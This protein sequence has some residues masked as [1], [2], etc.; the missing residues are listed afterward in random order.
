M[1]A[2]VFADPSVLGDAQARL[3]NP[4]I[5][6]EVAPELLRFAKAGHVSDSSNDAGSDHGIDPCD[7]QKPLDIGIVYRV[8]RDV[9]V[10]ICKV[11]GE[12]VNLAHVAGDRGPFVVRPAA[13]N[14]RGTRR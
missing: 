10:H 14:Q 2:S 11:F 3:T 6:T 9:A 4:R 12:T 13:Q 7:R 1:R 5:E 8:L